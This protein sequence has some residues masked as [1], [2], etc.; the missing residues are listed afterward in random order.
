[1]GDMNIRADGAVLARKGLGLIGRDAEAARVRHVDTNIATA[2]VLTLNATPVAIL[3][4]VGSGIYPV[5][6]GCVLFQDFNSA[7]Y[8]DDNDDAF[9]IQNLSAGSQVSESI[10]GTELDGGADFA[11]WVPPAAHLGSVATQTLVDNGGFEATI[12]SSELITGD[13]DWAVRLFYMLVHKVTLEGL[14]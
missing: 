1:M 9:H 10:D 8:V 14:P 3:A 4:A 5:F 12:E 6:L 13:S 7:A 2:D 11:I